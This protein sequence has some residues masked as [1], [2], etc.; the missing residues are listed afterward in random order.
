MNILIS[1]VGRQSFLV[2]A[3]KEALK[4][5]GKVF[6]TDC[7][8]NA[9]ALKIADKSFIAPPF[10]S[11]KYILWMLDICKNH[12][13]ELLLSFNVDDIII[14]EKY[15]KA[16]SNIGCILLGADYEICLLYTSLW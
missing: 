16:F 6:A 15:N 13:I 12:K 4:G 5:R 8:E 9:K 14:L 1:A 10:S 3:F 7:D 11:E 2:N